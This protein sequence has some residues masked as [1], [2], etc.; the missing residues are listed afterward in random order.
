MPSHEI[1]FAQGVGI[2]VQQEIRGWFSLLLLGL[3]LGHLMGQQGGV[4][5]VSGSCHVCQPGTVLVAQRNIGDIGNIG[6]IAEHW[7]RKSLG[8]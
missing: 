5:A 4:P 6:N 3:V 7:L 8:P 1:R 2:A